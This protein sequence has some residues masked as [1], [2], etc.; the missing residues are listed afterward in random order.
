MPEPS[1]NAAND[2]FRDVLKRV[3]HTLIKIGPIASLRDAGFCLM[4]IAIDMPS[5]PGRGLCKISS[6][7]VFRGFVN[8]WCC[9]LDISLQG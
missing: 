4:D 9:K 3:S 5:L 6:D 1:V 2:R 7:R 8:A